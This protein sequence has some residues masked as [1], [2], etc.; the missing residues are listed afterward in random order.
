MVDQSVRIFPI[1][2]RSG[3]HRGTDT[4]S[5]DK[6]RS[7]MKVVTVMNVQIYAFQEGLPPQGLGYG[8]IAKKVAG[9]E[10]VVSPVKSSHQW[11]PGR[12]K[13]SQRLP[14][15]WNSHNALF[16]ARCGGWEALG[17][18]FDRTSFLLKLSAHRHHWW[19][20]LTSVI[21]GKIRG[22]WISCSTT[23]AASHEYIIISTPY[24]ESIYA[25]VYE[26]C[27]LHEGNA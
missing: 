17:W 10:V 25:D 16:A 9:E 26:V 11:S 15:E 14:I 3:C 27:L 22:Y 7:I 2:L 23:C 12:Q 8:F 19:D 4:T 20:V 21:I 18:R 6:L 24:L 1:F 5:T 13:R